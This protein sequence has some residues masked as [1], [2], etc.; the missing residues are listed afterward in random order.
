MRPDRAGFRGNPAARPLLEVKFM[1]DKL[2]GGSNSGLTE[3]EAQEFHKHYISGLI[4]F[5]V[6]AVVAHILTYVW[7]PWFN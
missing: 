3:A 1:A 6:I 2:H 7:K 4:M 5:V